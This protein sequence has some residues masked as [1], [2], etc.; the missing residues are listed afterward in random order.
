MNTELSKLTR[1]LFWF[2]YLPFKLYRTVRNW[3]LPATVSAHDAVLAEQ[4][5]DVLESQMSDP[6]N[7]SDYL[8]VQQ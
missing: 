7:E 1:I 2:G 6:K 5:L 3:Y 4:D 8:E